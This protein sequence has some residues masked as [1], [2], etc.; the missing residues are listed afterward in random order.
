MKWNVHLKE[1]VLLEIFGPEI[2]EIEHLPSPTRT[3]SLRQANYFIE[4]GKQLLNADQVCTLT[5]LIPESDPVA[6]QQILIHNLRKVA[7]IAKRYTNRGLGLFEL[8]NEGTKGL[9]QAMEKLELEGG[10][11]F[12]AYAT[13]FI[14]RNIERAIMIQNMPLESFQNE[15]APWISFDN[16]AI[17]TIRT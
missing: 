2:T 5:N 4:I 3:I 7:S 9:I 15:S 12:S 17:C 6:K 13:K 11:R 1:D 16:A 10:F 14:C 8:V